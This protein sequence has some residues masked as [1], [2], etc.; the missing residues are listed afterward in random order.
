[1][2]LIDCDAGGI[3]GNKS[4]RFVSWILADMPQDFDPCSLRLMSSWS[5][6]SSRLCSGDSDSPRREFGGLDSASL[7]PFLGADL[8][9]SAAVMVSMTCAGAS[10]CESKGCQSICLA[11]RIRSLTSWIDRREK[12]REEVGDETYNESAN[13]ILD[14]VTAEIEVGIRVGELGK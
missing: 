8:R 2:S 10:A 11:R 4:I 5:I 14:P 6:S 3:D 1:M 9:P 7:S 12:R 13:E